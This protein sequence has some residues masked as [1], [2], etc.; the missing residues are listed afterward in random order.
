MEALR[1]VPCDCHVLACPDDCAEA[2]GPYA[3]RTGFEL[4]TGSKNDVLHRYCSAIRHFGIDRVIRATADNPF[5]FADAAFTLNNEA[6]ERCADYAAYNG[7]P[8]GAGV[9]PV[10]AEALLRAERDAALAPE[11]EHVCPYLYAHPEL[12]LLHRPVAPLVWQGPAVRVTVDTR[13][14]YERA[15]T[16][17]QALSERADGDARYCGERIVQTYHEM[18]DGK[19]TEHTERGGRL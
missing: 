14:D 10:S 6:T 18:F 5:V 13:E 2:F 11:R 12:F 9:E 8:Y 3:A 1:R 19:S 17:Y 7:I 15:V 16:L 4:F